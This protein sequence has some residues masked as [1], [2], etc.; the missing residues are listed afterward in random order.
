[1]QRLIQRHN[2][3]GSVADR[4]RSGRPR[5]TTQREDRAIGFV[6]ARNPFQP[7][8]TT[9]R[10]FRVSLKT[11]LRPLRERGIRAYRPLWVSS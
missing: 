10:A 6:H 5:A 3:T 1:M 7:G 4:P 8:A 2:A 9:A 11:V